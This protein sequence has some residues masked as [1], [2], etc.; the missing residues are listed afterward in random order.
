MVGVS[1]LL[2]LAAPWPLAILIDTL[3]GRR[4]LPGALRSLWHGVST[5][6]IIAITVLGGLLLTVLSQALGVLDS[7]VNTKLNLR[8]SL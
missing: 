8:L 3:T 1:A 2:G 5:G 7:Y 4:Q 6:E